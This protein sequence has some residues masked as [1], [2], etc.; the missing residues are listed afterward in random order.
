MSDASTVQMPTPMPSDEAWGML[1]LLGG[2]TLLVLDRYSRILY[3]TPNVKQLLGHSAEDLQ[4]RPMV[5]IYHHG[6]LERIGD[7]YEAA[8][9]R[10]ELV[11]A[12]HRCR[13]NNG[14]EVW[15]ESTTRAV[16]TD[17]GQ[18]LLVGLRREPGSP[19]A[20]WTQA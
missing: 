10:G 17:D 16:D 8:L 14:N 11:L 2:H 20:A 13:H 5:D 1:G 15:V 6:D 19:D 4:G 9:Y 12:R 18:R 3:A 7:G